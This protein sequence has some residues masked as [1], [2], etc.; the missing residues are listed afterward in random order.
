MQWSFA[1]ATACMDDPRI[2]ADELTQL[3]Q[4]AEMGRRMCVHHLQIVPGAKNHRRI[5]MIPR[6]V[7]ILPNSA[8]PREQFSYL[9]HAGRFYSRDEG[10]FQFVVLANPRG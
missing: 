1:V 5:E 9:A 6:L 4:H 8:V 3:V 7:D 10:M 2:S